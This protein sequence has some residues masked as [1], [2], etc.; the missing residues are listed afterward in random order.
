[1]PGV[2]VPPHATD[3]PDPGHHRPGCSQCHPTWHDDVPERRQRDIAPRRTAPEVP[4][5]AGRT[6]GESAAEPSSSHGAPHPRRHGYPAG[7]APLSPRTWRGT[8][9]RRPAQG[10]DAHLRAAA[11]SRADTEMGSFIQT[12]SNLSWIATAMLDFPERGGPLRIT[13]WPVSSNCVTCSPYGSR[14]PSRPH[15]R[16]SALAD[17]AARPP[18]DTAQAPRAQCGRSGHRLSAGFGSTSVL[19][20][21]RACP[22]THPL[23]T[24]LAFQ[25]A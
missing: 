19:V 14:R 23:T 18:T 16:A 11:R 7:C 8:T 24:S 15:H 9:S 13:V 6:C 5:V 1:M 17:R 10:R 21:D 4:R 25:Y 22:A 3:S 2:C 20:A 12:P